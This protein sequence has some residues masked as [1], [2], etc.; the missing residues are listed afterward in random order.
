MAI[1]GE[2]FELLGDRDDVALLEVVRSGL[3]HESAKTAS[4][5]F[6]ILFDEF[7]AAKALCDQKYL[8]ELKLARERFLSV[9]RLRDAGFIRERFPP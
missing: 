1:A 9:K 6:G 8:K 2:A 5:P 4:V 3:A 7:L